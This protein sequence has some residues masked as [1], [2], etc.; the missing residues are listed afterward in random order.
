MQTIAT[1]RDVSRLLDAATWDEL[2]ARAFPTLWSVD[3]G[4]NLD[5]TAPPDH[6][7][8]AFHAY[9]VASVFRVRAHEL[10]EKSG[11][12]MA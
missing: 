7:R 5:T 9:A 3:L 8:T 12:R 6:R 10:A 1:Q 11:P 2:R 4:Q